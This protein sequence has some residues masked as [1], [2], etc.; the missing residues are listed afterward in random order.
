MGRSSEV[1]SPS[2][3][4]L[5]VSLEVEKKRLEHIQK[6][7][8]EED[9]TQTQM[10]G[11]CFIRPYNQQEGFPTTLHGGNSTVSLNCSEN[12]YPFPAKMCLFIYSAVTGRTV[13]YSSTWW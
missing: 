8:E 3:T 10:R 12:H 5:R 4:A 13:T 9:Y 1:M 7:L 2:V 6:K 11:Y